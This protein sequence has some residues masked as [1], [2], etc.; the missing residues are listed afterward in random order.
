MWGYDSEEDEELDENEYYGWLE[1]KRR[2]V[3]FLNL[4]KH[5]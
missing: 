1:S 2:R 4:L 5:A 3:R